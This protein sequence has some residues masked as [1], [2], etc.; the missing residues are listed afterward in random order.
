M[1]DLVAGL[2]IVLT[3]SAGLFFVALRVGKVSCPVVRRRLATTCVAAIVGYAATLW[4][5]TTLADVL[6]YSNLILLGNWF[7][8][9][10]AILAGLVY[11][12][13][14]ESRRVFV[15]TS[16]LATA[17]FCLIQPLIGSTPKCRNQWDASGLCIQ[18]TDATCS[19]ACA[20]SLLRMHGIKTTEQ[21][22]ADLCLTR[23]GT[24]WQGLYRALKTKTQGTIW[25]VEVVE[26]PLEE[27]WKQHGKCILRVGL[28]PTSELADE[29]RVEAGWRSDVDHSV[30][31]LGVEQSGYTQVFDPSPEYGRECWSPLVMQELYRGHAVRL[32]PRRVVPDNA[33]AS[34]F[35]MVTSSLGINR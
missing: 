12:D 10:A 28:D 17:T 25:D 16:L 30:L 27:L 13:L 29:L 3:L 35:A 20:A 6:P 24:R 5:S 18:T 4:D 2:T 33:I 15:T 9:G 34:T 21:E 8:F 22:M 26:F 31:Y 11:P 19:A 7:P 1:S 14:P 23:K 32:I